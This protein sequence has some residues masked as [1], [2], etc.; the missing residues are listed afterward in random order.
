VGTLLSRVVGDPPFFPTPGF[1]FYPPPF[2]PPPPPPFF[3]SFRGQ[4]G[5]AFRREIWGPEGAILEP[6]AQPLVG[7]GG[8]F[9]PPKIHRESPLVR[10]PRRRFRG[11]LGRQGS[12]NVGRFS[13]PRF[14][15][16]GFKQ[17]CG[18]FMGFLVVFSACSG[19]PGQKAWLGGSLVCR[20]FQPRRRIPRPPS[21]HPASFRTLTPSFHTVSFGNPG[22]PGARGTIDDPTVHGGGRPLSAR[23]VPRPSNPPHKQT[24]LRVTP[25]P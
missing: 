12:G 18:L 20:L 21:V 22:P 9:Y 8:T 11:P 25:F 6:R 19:P 14:F 17:K 16:G 13:G 5:P 24:H 3:F 4:A 1:H 7:P 2:F 23:C 15:R 10:E